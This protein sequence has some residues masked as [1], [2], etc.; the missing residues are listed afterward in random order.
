MSMHGEDVADRRA[1]LRTPTKIEHI[2]APTWPAQVPWKQ[3]F[4]KDDSGSIVGVSI[5]SSHEFSAHPSGKQKFW[6]LKH[7]QSIAGR[8]P[9]NPSGRAFFCKRKG[10]R[11]R[12]SNVN[13]L[14]VHQSEHQAEEIRAQSLIDNA[15]LRIEWR[16]TV[17]K[18]PKAIND[19]V[20]I[21]ER[22]RFALPSD[23]MSC[24]MV[25]ERFQP[26]AP[27]LWY[28]KCKLFIKEIGQWITLTADILHEFAVAPIINP[29]WS[30]KKEKGQIGA[31]SLTPKSLSTGKQD[32]K[33]L[34]HVIG[35]CKDDHGRAIL[36]G[37]YYYTAEDAIELGKLLEEDIPENFVRKEEVFEE[38]MVHF[39]PLHAIIDYGIVVRCSRLRWG[40]YRRDK[41]IKN[42]SKGYFSRIVL[43]PANTTMGGN[44]NTRS[45]IVVV[46]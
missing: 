3:N 28:R 36:A 14:I 7:N 22:H 45:T 33:L 4:L 25:L 16:G 9:K 39:V 8:D 44:N 21:C 43:A 26:K 29:T 24:Q 20:V 2:L 34:M 42:A 35:L 6:N 19:A 27:T 18:V 10:C 40:T 32:R 11:M 23:C 1:R 31:S 15:S 37:R 13:D 38:E 17:S 5:W 46:K 41:R 30:L 12:F